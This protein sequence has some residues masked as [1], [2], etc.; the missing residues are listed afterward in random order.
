[1]QLYSFPFLCKGIFA[2]GRTHVPSA[3][4]DFQVVAG[5][6]ALFK[7]TMGSDSKAQPDLPKIFFYMLGGL[8]SSGGWYIGVSVQV[9]WRVPFDNRVK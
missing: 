4:Q 6:L 5:R 3:G 8:V 1:M 7:L 2:F 9:C